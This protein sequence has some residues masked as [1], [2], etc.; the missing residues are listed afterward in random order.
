M[1]NRSYSNFPAQ[2]PSSTFDWTTIES[3]EES[4]KRL[5]TLRLEWNRASFDE[6][7]RRMSYNESRSRLQEVWDKV[8]NIRIHIKKNEREIEE[9]KIE[10]ILKDSEEVRWEGAIERI[11]DRTDALTL[12]NASNLAGVQQIR[13]KFRLKEVLQAKISTLELSLS[14]YQ[15]DLLVHSERLR[16]QTF[17]AS[18]PS[19]NVSDN[20]SLTLVTESMNSRNMMLK[21][22]S[23]INNIAIELKEY[24]LELKRIE[25]DIHDFIETRDSAKSAAK[26]NKSMLQ[27]P[28]NAFYAPQLFPPS[29]MLNK[30]LILS[31]EDNDILIELVSYGQPL[32]KDL[33]QVLVTS[34]ELQSLQSLIQL[35]IE[36]ETDDII[37]LSLD[38][39]LSGQARI[40]RINGEDPSLYLHRL[41]KRLVALK[42]LELS[43]VKE[44]L[45]LVQAV[46]RLRELVRF[47][48]LLIKKICLIYMN[49]IF[50][51]TRSRD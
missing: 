4:I 35:P 41:Q 50:I 31:E 1:E 39:V 24:K 18:K 21:I 44:F 42:Q 12:H 47:C 9:T 26:N 32:S 51:V 3:N 48:A 25:K 36:N 20:L 13:D 14:E 23:Q 22:S 49:Y 34:G 37:E 10:S 27:T 45:L 16:N 7:Q 43:L 40:Y 5:E 30:P 19:S 6:N 29:T 28:P 17:V 11:Q 15:R 33:V 2:T 38:E 8:V 46:K